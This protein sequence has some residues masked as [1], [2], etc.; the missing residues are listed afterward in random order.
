MVVGRP[1]VEVVEGAA[2]K[3]EEDLEKRRYGETPVFFW[4]SCIV[5]SAWISKL[6]GVDDVGNRPWAMIFA[7]LGCLDQMSRGSE[8]CEWILCKSWKSGKVGSESTSVQ[9]IGI[10]LLPV[11]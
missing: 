7:G 2:K 6:R 5:D 3:R 9:R 8:S 11:P 10:V 4:V 1:R